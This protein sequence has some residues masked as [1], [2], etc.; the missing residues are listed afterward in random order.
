MKKIAKSTRDKLNKNIRGVLALFVTLF[1]A[2]I[3]Y[4]G[5]SVISFGDEWTQTPYN[6]RIHKVIKNMTEGSIYDINGERLAWSVDEDSPRSYMDSATNRR[7]MS[8]VLGDTHGMSVGAESVFTSY[9]YGIKD[10][11]AEAGARKGNDITL[12]VDTDLSRFIY[13]NF[14]GKQ[15]SAVVM[16]YKTG[17]ILANVS[18][19]AFDPITVAEDKLED[20]ALLDRAVMGRFPPGS[21][22]K[23][24]TASAAVEEDIDITYTCKGQDII[25]GQKVTCVSAHG[26]QNLEQAFENSCNCYFARLSNEIGSQKLLATANRFGFNVDWD[27]DDIVLYE[28]NFELSSSEGDIAWAGIGQYNDLITPMHACMIAGTIANDGNMMVPKL[29]YKAVNENGRQTYQMQE[30]TY[31]NVLEAETTQ[32]IKEYMKNVVKS[33][34]GTSA[35]VSGMDIGGKTGTAEYVDKDT[36]KVKN[37]SWF[38][39]FIDDE[40]KPYC[41]AVIFEGAGFG[42]KYAA[43]MAG[44]I[45]SY[46]NQNY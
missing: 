18:L 44:K 22:M 7:V 46:I 8:H 34:T 36:G 19:P 27:F 39:G 13:D 23:V 4:L 11:S 33:G 31:S 41:V 10:G 45:F 43:P 25:D 21:I 28:S 38:I 37:H 35:G 14:A 26:T 40:D 15:G 2:I 30:E 1:A 16:N 3:V 20:G 17:E 32:T 6:P 42:S 24:V 5:Y 29:L 9:L 12:T